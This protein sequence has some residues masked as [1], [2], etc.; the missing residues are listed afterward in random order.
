MVEHRRRQATLLGRT[1]N[2]PLH[3]DDAPPRLPEWLER[4]LEGRCPA[5]PADTPRT[6]ATTMDAVTSVDDHLASRA[7]TNEHDVFGRT[8]EEAT[9][10][11]TKGVE[12]TTEMAT[13]TFPV[14]KSVVAKSVLATEPRSTVLER[15]TMGVGNEPRV[16][17]GFRRMLVGARGPVVFHTAHGVDVLPRCTPTHAPILPTHAP[18]LPMPAERPSE[19]AASEARDARPRPPRPRTSTT[20]N[21]SDAPSSRRVGLHLLPWAIAAA[22]FAF[23]GALKYL[24]DR[25]LETDLRGAVH[26]FTTSLVVQAR[27]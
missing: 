1:M 25:G 19:R 24:D 2:D 3:S 5:R 27:P 14:A 9:H 4:K 20:S 26:A 8:T 11:A 15:T 7:T 21:G 12:R 6:G 22:T 17:M 16:A 13:L 10:A 18:V 23:V